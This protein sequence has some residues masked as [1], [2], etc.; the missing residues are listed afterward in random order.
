MNNNSKINGNNGNNN[1][2]NNGGIIMTT[3]TMNTLDVFADTIRAALAEHYGDDYCV[4]VM[5]VTK[6]NDVKLTGITIKESGCNVAPTIYLNQAFEDYHKGRPVSD[7]LKEIMKVYEQNRVPE[8]FNVQW[9]MDFEQVRDKLCLKLV[10]A[11]RNSELLSDAPFVPFNDLAIIFYVLVGS[12]KNGT[13]TV[14]VRNSLMETWG[15]GAQD[16]YEV[17]I[18]NT[19]R[20]M[21]GKVSTMG[22]VLAE[23][24]DSKNSD[25]FYDMEGFEDGVPLFVASNA[26]KLNGAA[27][28]LYPGLL[29]E[30]ASRIGKAFYILPSSIH[31]CLF[32]PDDEGADVDTLRMMVREV[33]ETQVAPEEV[34]SDSVYRYDPETDAVVIA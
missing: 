14:T 31:E 11:D 8:C 22:S 27:V 16:L 33:N 26:E 9:I 21:R 24:M 30:F 18:Q 10:N 2:F 25:E 3:G 6:T 5:A 19:Q 12:G 28:I 23:L 7:I 13:A 4:E 1:G 17:A 32:L 34:L 15:V 20:L 29:K